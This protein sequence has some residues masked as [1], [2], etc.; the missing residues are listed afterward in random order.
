MVACFAAV[1]VGINHPFVIWPV[2]IPPSVFFCAYFWRCLGDPAWVKRGHRAIIIGVTERP[3]QIADQM[4]SRPWVE[5]LFLGRMRKGNTGATPRCLWAWLYREFGPILPYWGW[6][7][8]PLAASTVVLGYASQLLLQWMFLIFGTAVAAN[9]L[10]VASSML[11]PEGRRE[12]YYLTL[13]T[14]GL[15]TLTLAVASLGIVVLSWLL[16]AVLP[17]IPWEGHHLRYVEIGM[18]SIWLACLPVP[19]LFGAN[20]I[21]HRVPVVRG[22]ITVVVALL[23]IGETFF[24]D[25]GFREALISVPVLVVCGWVYFPLAAWITFR[26]WDLAGQRPVGND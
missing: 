3:R 8:V 2:L 11:L 21:G 19:W 23:L 14:A 20:P 9:V 18:N 17:Q 1:W 12:R 15:A 7:V 26:R 6:I 10:P 16:A 5:E 24:R 25:Y 13:A 4:Q 22:A